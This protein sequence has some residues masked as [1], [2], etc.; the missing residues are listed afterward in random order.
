MLF[1]RRAAWVWV[2][3]V[4]IVRISK[5]PSYAGQEKRVQGC[6]HLISFFIQNMAL[7]NVGRGIVGSLQGLKQHKGNIF[8][9]NLKLTQWTD[10]QFQETWYFILYYYF[11]YQVNILF[12][13]R[14]G[15]TVHSG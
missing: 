10:S 9:K 2:D 7:Q 5:T 1:R 12:I 4:P 3:C 14:M 8:T 6:V 11:F 15:I 13:R